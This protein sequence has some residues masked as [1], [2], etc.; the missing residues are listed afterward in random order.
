MKVR[1]EGEIVE[2]P[3]LVAVDLLEPVRVKTEN[4]KTKVI[5]MNTVIFTR[6]ESLI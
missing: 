6:E 3:Y 1:M 2:E 5:P 4:G